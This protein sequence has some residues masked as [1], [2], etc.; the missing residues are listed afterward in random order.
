MDD[1]LGVFY[2]KSSRTLLVGLPAYHIMTVVNE[3][4]TCSI[5]FE[6]ILEACEFEIF[7]IKDISFTTIENYK[8]ITEEFESS[9][10]LLEE[11]I[12]FKKNRNKTKLAVVL[13][14]EKKGTNHAD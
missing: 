9:E 5:P 6:D 1:N 2:I 3:F 13:P 7:D 12:E 4:T 11:F 10:Q 14:I 8:K